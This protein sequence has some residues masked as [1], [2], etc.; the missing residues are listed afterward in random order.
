MK[1]TTQATRQLR[2]PLK[3]KGTL[4]VP[5]RS[6]LLASS[7]S[8]ATAIATPAAVTMGSFSCR[9][10]LPGVSLPVPNASLR[11]WIIAYHCYTTF[12]G[13]QGGG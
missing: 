6:L 4:V 1:T 5:S 7:V 11:R 12:R 10:L 2:K 3:P 9:L 13:D 8:P